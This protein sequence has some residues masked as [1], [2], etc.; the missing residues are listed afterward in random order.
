MGRPQTRTPHLRAHSPRAGNV[1]GP[2]NP[3]SALALIAAALL[4]AGCG[5]K[6]EDASEPSGTFRVEVA[7]ASF[8]AHQRIA[9]PVTLR[10]R[11]RNADH[12]ALPDVAVTVQT[13]PAHPGQA[14][15]AFGQTATDTRLA[16]PRRPVWIVDKGPR[17]GDTAY[18]NT[19]AL[20]ALRPGRTREFV[21]HLLPARA[22]AYTVSYRLFPGLS[23]RARPARGRTGGSFRVTVANEPVPACVGADG[24]VIT[25]K[26][27][28]ENRC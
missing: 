20:G 9:Q 13:R 25:G 6:A 2:M 23:S 16:D 3:R 14:P 7:G 1:A 15:I 5:G 10:I 27:A 21:W 22:G 4:A 17:G 12:R 18:T 19:W 11:V 28:A 26:R 8:P 24:Q